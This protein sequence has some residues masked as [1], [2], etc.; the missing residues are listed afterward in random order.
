MVGEVCANRK[1]LAAWNRIY[2]PITIAFASAPLKWGCG[3]DIKEQ[4]SP[5]T[6]TESLTLLPQYA[7]FCC[8]MIRAPTI[9]LGLVTT[10]VGWGSWGWLM[11]GFNWVLQGT[12]EGG[13]I[14][15]DGIAGGISIC[16][17]CARLDCE[18]VISDW[19][20]TTFD[21][22]IEL[23]AT[24]FEAPS[25]FSGNWTRLFDADGVF[26]CGFLDCSG[27]LFDDCGR[28]VINVI[29][30]PMIIFAFILEYLQT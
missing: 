29:L 27:P 1:N 11:M 15:R 22:A 16:S 28:A 13:G 17:V 18:W 25:G 20:D 9:V 26:V 8:W 19:G 21:T 24:F 23:S 5:T 6:G 30:K 14:A 4:C 10:G 3:S 2:I 12:A 7:C